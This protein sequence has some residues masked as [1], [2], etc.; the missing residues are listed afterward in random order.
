M[1][2]NNQQ[3]SNQKRDKGKGNAFPG[4]EQGLSKGF[5]INTLNKIIKVKKPDEKRSD[6]GKKGTSE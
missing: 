4:E 6:K 2:K 3:R 1:A 5:F